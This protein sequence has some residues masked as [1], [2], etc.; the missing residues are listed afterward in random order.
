MGRASHA[1]ARRR[2][3]SLARTPT[4]EFALS[5]MGCLRHHRQEMRRRPGR[6]LVEPRVP[7]GQRFGHRCARLVQSR[8]VFVHLFQQALAGRTDRVAR[9]TTT[10]RAFK[11]PASSFEVKPN[12]IALRTKSSRAT[13]SS[14]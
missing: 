14:E 12:L 9:R 1:R 7:G 11:K 6:R 2:C 5:R 8:Q 4:D 10:S 3:T 13:V